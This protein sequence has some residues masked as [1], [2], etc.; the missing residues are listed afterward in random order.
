MTSANAYAQEFELL[1]DNAE[2]EEEQYFW[3][4]DG[5]FSGEGLRTPQ[6]LKMPKGD[7]IELG[8]LGKRERERNT[9]DTK[10]V[11]KRAR[12]MQESE[13]SKK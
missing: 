1:P 7:L 10:A 9:D 2:S 5:P 8:I 3:D 4:F 13:D 11:K 6:K 12:T